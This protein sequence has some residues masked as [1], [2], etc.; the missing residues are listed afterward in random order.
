MTERMELP[1]NMGVAQDDIYQALME[2]HD[3]LSDDES[4]ALNA[5]LVLILSNEVGGAARLLQ[6]FAL[7]RSYKAS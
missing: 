6:L 3:G 1:D 5:R 4:H 2:A 7:A